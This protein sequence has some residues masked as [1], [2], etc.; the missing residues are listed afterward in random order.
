M[1]ANSSYYT[2]LTTVPTIHLC[3]YC[4]T[5]VYAGNFRGAMQFIGDPNADGPPGRVTVSETDQVVAF[6]QIHILYVFIIS[7]QLNSSSCCLIV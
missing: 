3:N 5:A 6:D 7:L 2:V 4:S 1:L